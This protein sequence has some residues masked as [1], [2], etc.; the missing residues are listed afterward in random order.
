MEYG[1]DFLQLA[2]R[3][4][5]RLKDTKDVAKTWGAGGL[6]GHYLS[7]NFL[8]TPKFNVDFPNSQINW[9]PNKKWSFYARPDST[10]ETGKPTGI[11][12]G[13]SYNF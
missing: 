9:K 6:L 10:T 1:R 12:L 5:D 2:K 7:M 4:L 13:G 8:N 11:Q 3:D